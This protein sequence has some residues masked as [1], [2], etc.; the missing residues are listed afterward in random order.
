MPAIVS[1]AKQMLLSSDYPLDKVVGIKNGSRG[2]ASFPGTSTIVVPHGL[3]FAPL[4][5]GQWS[6]SPDFSVT[7]EFGSGPVGNVLRFNYSVSSYIFSDATNLTMEVSNFLD[8]PIT[9]YYRIYMFQ[10]TTYNVALPFT[11]AQ[12]DTFTLNT[13]YNYTKLFMSGHINSPAPTN[14]VITHGLGYA[15]QVIYWD[16]LDNGNIRNEPVALMLIPFQSYNTGCEVTTNELVIA[17]SAGTI[18]L[19]YRIYIDE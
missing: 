12:A 19:H 1:N 7:Y 8:N 2:V 17:P 6:L 14:N 15:P 11:A 5:I 13:D 4:F 3:P 18:R 9:F 10:P 16:E